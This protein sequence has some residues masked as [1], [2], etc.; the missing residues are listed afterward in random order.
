MRPRVCGFDSSRNVAVLRIE[1]RAIHMTYDQLQW[2]NEM[3]GM[4][5]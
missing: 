2:P 5:I 1:M 4:R 3:E